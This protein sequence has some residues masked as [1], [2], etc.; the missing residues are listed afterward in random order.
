MTP[1]AGMQ[2]MSGRGDVRVG[3]VRRFAQ[4]VVFALRSCIGPRRW[5]GLLVPAAGAVLFGLIAT[6]GDD[7]RA[8]FARVAVDG[9]LAL[10]LPVASLVVGDAVLGAEIRRGTFHFTW[11]SPVPAGRIVVA[12]WLA[13]WL[14]AV[15]TL[16]PGVVLAA[17]VAGAPG[18]APPLAVATIAGSA[19]YVAVFVLIGAVAR[20]AAV[21]SLAFVFL[22]ERLL[23]TA[24]TGVAQWS[25][26]WEAGATYVGLSDHAPADLVRD[27]IPAGG[28]AIG[29]LALLTVIALVLARWRLGHLR[30][31]GPSD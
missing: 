9:I 24:V 3:E 13:G 12:R 29:R 26:T 14:A 20:R 10:V 5:A 21:W 27:G 8:E 31:R 30:H 7:Q 6:T 4:L 23:G 11:L 17:V 1:A 15:A 25:P 16:V 18:E 19:A 28:A 22:V 2:R